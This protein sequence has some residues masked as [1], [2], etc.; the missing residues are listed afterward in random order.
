M[1]IRS[2]LTFLLALLATAVLESPARAVE[3]GIVETFGQTKPTAQTASELGAGWVRIWASWEAAEPER[4][5]W[6]PWVVTKLNADV[7][8]AKAKGL[9]VLVV[10]Q[11]TPAWASGGKGGIQP[12]TDPDSF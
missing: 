5:R 8:A 11:R 10:V 1:R 2:C 7:N 4:G 12:P 6:S 9:R 3:T